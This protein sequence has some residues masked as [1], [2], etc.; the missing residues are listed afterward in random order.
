MFWLGSS[1]GLGREQREMLVAL[2]VRDFLS[3]PSMV[4]IR[5]E[6]VWEAGARDHPSQG[7]WSPKTGR[8]VTQ[9]RVVAQAGVVASQGDGK[10]ASLGNRA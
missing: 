1:R 3:M 8:V 5:S 2:M 6:F 7:A 10:L 9:A 4:A